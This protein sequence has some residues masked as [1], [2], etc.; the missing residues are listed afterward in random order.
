MKKNLTTLLMACAVYTSGLAQTTATGPSSSQSP[1]F[2]PTATGYSIT[3]IITTPDAIGTYSM[4][5]IPDGLGAFD[6]NDGTFTLLM[7]QEIGNTLGATRAHGSIGA[8]VSKWK[9]NKSTLTV[10]SGSDLMQNV[11]LWNPATSTYSTYNATTPSTL[12]AFSRFCSADMPATTALYNSA[13]GRGTQERIFMNGE[14]SGNEGRLMA[15]IVTGA[16]SGNSYE[17]PYLGKYSC[18]NIC[19]NPHRSDKTIVIGMDDTTPGQVYVYVGNKTTT[20]TDITKAGLTGGVL[21]GVSVSGLLNE[22]SGSIPTANTSFSLVNLGAVQAI[23]GTSLNTVSNNLNV[24]NFLRPEDGSW[25]PSNHRDFYFNTTNAFNSPSRV[26]RLRFND[27][28]NPE[29]GGTITAVLDGT[30]GQQMLDN[31][32]IDNSGH[33]MLQEDVG[34]NAWN[35]RIL[36]YDIATDVLTPIGQHDP[37]RFITGG[38]GF[39]T[40]DEEASGIVDVNLGCSQTSINW[41]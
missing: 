18:E 3:S 8:F 10:I 24:T 36:Q 35:G 7:N 15:H 9:I 19:A 27:I 11:N 22:T 6:N 31:M 32:T 4:A 13:T 37:A 25:D 41:E 38:A 26:W 29:L 30:E 14:E 12:A 39:L 16:A 34:N 20:G 23:T 5:G 40:Q 17:L 33:I 28:E 1:Y 2:L 21:Y